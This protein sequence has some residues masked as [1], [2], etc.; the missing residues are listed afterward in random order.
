MKRMI[1]AKQGFVLFRAEAFGLEGEVK[2][3]R[4]V[5]AGAL[6]AVEVQFVGGP[7]FQMLP[8]LFDFSRNCFGSVAKL[9]YQPDMIRQGEAPRNPENVV[10]KIAGAAVGLEVLEGVIDG[11]CIHNC[12]RGGWEGRPLRACVSPVP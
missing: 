8:C 2:P 6:G 4:E 5:G 12:V 1:A 10:G 3:Q 9:T 11:G 7:V